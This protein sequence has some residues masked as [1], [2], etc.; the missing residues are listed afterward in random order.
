MSAA[1]LTPPP[2][3]GPG[4]EKKSGGGLEP[5]GIN[6]RT[7]GP[8]LV[9]SV[10]LDATDGLW[11]FSVDNY[12]QMLEHGIL[13]EG[14][15]VELL[16]GLLVQKMPTSTDH[17]TV[18]RLVAALLRQ[19]VPAGWFVDEDKPMTI[20]P[21]SEPEPDTSVIRGR[22]RD[23]LRRHPSPTDTAL[24]VE[25]SYSSYARDRGE[26]W[27]IYARDGVPVYW[28]VNLEAAPARLEVYSLP[29]DGE[30]T[31]AATLT[32]ADRADVVL[33]GVVVGSVAVAELLP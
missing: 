30:Y 18:A 3:P 5:G 26:K 32:A 10:P 16:D 22:I 31:Q 12:H 28:I 23:Y 27:A 25:V 7:P 4:Q 2:Q 15:P 17:A 21:R 6:P 29:V 9:E 20:Q 19:V 24:V 13:W 14:A 1:V 8:P 33:D 11:R